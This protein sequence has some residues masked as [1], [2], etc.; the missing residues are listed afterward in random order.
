[1]LMNSKTYG[2]IAELAVAAKL[3]KMGYIVSRPLSDNAPY[4]LIIDKNGTLQKVQ[5]KARKSRKGCVF[6]ELYSNTT[7]GSRMYQKKD[8]DILAIYHIETGDIALVDHNEIN[9]KQ[10]ILQI[11]SSK[12]FSKNSPSMKFF[13]DY[14]QGL[15]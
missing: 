8:F 2:D 11:G 15:L 9:T 14:S 5:V 4:D 13:E 10:L 3:A 6:V 1:M 12:R 7:S